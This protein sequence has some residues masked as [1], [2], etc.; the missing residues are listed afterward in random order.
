MENLWPHIRPT[1][2]STDAATLTEGAR[3]GPLGLGLLCLK[4]VRV[5]AHGVPEAGPACY[6]AIHSEPSIARTQSLRPVLCIP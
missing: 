2:V 4:C 6:R 1:T 3:Q 5:C